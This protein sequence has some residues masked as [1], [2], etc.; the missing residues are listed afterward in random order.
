MDKD[1][2]LLQMTMLIAKQIE[3]HGYSKVAEDCSRI[4]QEHYGRVNEDARKTA[5]AMR[6]RMAKGEPWD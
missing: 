4:Q 3:K 1:E 2:E 6:D 5:Q